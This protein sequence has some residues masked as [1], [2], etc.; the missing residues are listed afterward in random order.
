VSQR[1]PCELNNCGYVREDGIN[2]ER[3]LTLNSTHTRRRFCSR[4][5]EQVIPGLHTH[6]LT[7]DCFVGS[8]GFQRLSCLL[9]A[10]F[11][12]L[13]R[14]HILH[15]SL[16]G[17]Y[18]VRANKWSVIKF[19]SL[20]VEGYAYGMNLALFSTWNSFSIYN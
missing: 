16:C 8:S 11:M 3:R 14:Q 1:A 15:E 9:T 17:C 19:S 2:I 4:R 5:T 18:R 6:I 10:P 7:L 12:N 13:I 20:A